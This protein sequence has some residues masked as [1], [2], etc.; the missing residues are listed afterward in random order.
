M[1]RQPHPL[2]VRH[3]IPLNLEI[4][5]L[6]AWNH[7]IYAKKCSVDVLKDLNL[8]STKNLARMNAHVV[9]PNKKGASDFRVGWGE[10][11]GDR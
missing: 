1:S 3:L 6:I 9:V 10:K 7:L 4:V 2:Q 8:H 11:M 5:H